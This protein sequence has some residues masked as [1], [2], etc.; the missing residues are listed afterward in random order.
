MPG[1]SEKLRALTE[2]AV[3]SAGSL[4]LKIQQT[5]YNLKSDPNTPVSTLTIELAEISSDAIDDSVFGVPPDFQL[6]S[7]AEIFKPLTFVSTAPQAP[8]R[9]DLTP[10]EQIS[11]IGGGVS[12]PAVIYKLNPKY[13]EEARRAKLEG[14][15][16]LKIVVDVNGVAKNIQVAKSLG[17][18]LDEKAI[19]AVSQWKFRPGQKD[20][21]P[22]NVIATVV[23]NFKLVDRP[24]QQ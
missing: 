8:I 4:T 13:T 3:T 7:A 11:R 2:E 10:G 20:G 12:A 9:P 23:V 18:G 15:V 14:A 21:Q 1:A 24:P 22:V 16:L 19:E 6:V 5:V 17:L